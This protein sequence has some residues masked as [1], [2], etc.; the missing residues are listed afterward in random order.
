MGFLQYKKETGSR[1]SDNNNHKTRAVKK[2]KSIIG[3]IMYILGVIF[4]LFCFI[5]FFIKKKLIRILKKIRKLD[6]VFK[7]KII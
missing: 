4:V 1:V 2:N 6:Y 7:D 5:F 3:F